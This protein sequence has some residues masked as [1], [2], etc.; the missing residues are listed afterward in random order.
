MR[1]RLQ[2]IG[3]AIKGLRTVFRQEKNFQIQTVVALIVFVLMMVT[4]LTSFERIILILL[5]A[6]VLL[7]E[8]TNT[9]LEYTL[10]I[11]RP[12]V[13][14]TVGIVKDIMA[15]AVLVG[16]LAAVTIGCIIFLPYVTTLVPFLF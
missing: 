5:V 6:L 14:P 12:R 11:F 7:L 8:I 4:P 10:D 16:T 2:S 9:A 3:F 1:K 13:H 15:G